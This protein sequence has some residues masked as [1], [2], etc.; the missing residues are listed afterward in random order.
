MTW[1]H[2]LKRKEYNAV[3]GHEPNEKEWN[4]INFNSFSHKR[5]FHIYMSTWSEFL[6]TDP[7]VLGSIPGASR[8]SERQ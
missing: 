2:T 4:K 7:E 8:F 6:A 3:R 5:P 1:S